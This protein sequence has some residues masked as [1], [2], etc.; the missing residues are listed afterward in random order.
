MSSLSTSL[1][2]HVI[3][4]MHKVFQFKVAHAHA[5]SC[6]QKK[7]RNETCLS[8]AILCFFTRAKSFPQHVCFFGTFLRS[9]QL[10]RAHVSEEQSFFFNR[11]VDVLPKW[12]VLQIYANTQHLRVQ[13]TMLPHGRNTP[14]AE[15]FSTIL[16]RRCID[17]LAEWFKHVSRQLKKHQEKID[18]SIHTNLRTGTK[19]QPANNAVTE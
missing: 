2:Q 3:C 13:V 7:M 12:M 14:F 9:T 4:G 16:T 18:T 6:S 15:K 10:P 1:C 11:H 17:S 5:S 19:N 8:R